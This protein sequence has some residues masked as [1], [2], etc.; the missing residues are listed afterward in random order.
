MRELMGELPSPTCRHQSVV[1]DRTHEHCLCLVIHLQSNRPGLERS[2]NPT[3]PP[4]LLAQVCVL[5]LWSWNDPPR[6]GHPDY[7]TSARGL[8]AHQ[9]CW[10]PSILRFSLIEGAFFAALLGYSLVVASKTRGM[11]H[12]PVLAREARVLSLVILNGA[13]SG[14][15]C[16][17]FVYLYRDELKALA[18]LRCIALVYPAG[19]AVLATALPKVFATPSI[20]DATADV[21]DAAAEAEEEGDGPSGKGEGPPL[22]CL[23]RS[24]Q[25]IQDR[26]GQLPQCIAE[27]I[28]EAQA[29]AKAG[30]YN[31]RSLVSKKKRRYK[32]A[33]S[34]Q[35][36]GFD[37]DLTYITDRCATKE[38]ARRS[39]RHG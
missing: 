16:G 29:G 4:F 32:V 38:T 30:T 33:A 27:V 21:V 28:E 22:P 34:K 7:P 18:A 2:R 36:G 11:D 9:V 6:L 39:I 19:V 35:T 31:V 10:N 8:D 37:L 5:L 17:V 13:F 15:C 24:L 14:I 20:D 26:E 1:A 25:A 23:P 3:E 12:E